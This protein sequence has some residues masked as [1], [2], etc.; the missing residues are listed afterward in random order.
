MP[1][2]SLWKDAYM[3]KWLARKS[4]VPIFHLKLWWHRSNAT[5]A[6]IQTANFALQIIKG[7]ANSA[8]KA[9]QYAQ[10]EQLMN[11]LMTISSKM[12]FVFAV[13]PVVRA[14]LQRDNALGAIQTLKCSKIWLIKFANA[15]VESM[16]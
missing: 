5:I 2:P 8:K 16:E 12:V 13:L 9:L 4:A 14:V 3:D 15:Q 7:C 6:R 1:F 10:M 11:V